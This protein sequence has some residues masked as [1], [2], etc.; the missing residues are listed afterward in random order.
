MIEHERCQS[1][2]KKEQTGPSERSFVGT[3]LISPVTLGKYTCWDLMILEQI[4]SGLS[5]SLITPKHHKG[6]T[7]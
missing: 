6:I 7:L 5:L 4:F 1:G 2:E 3:V